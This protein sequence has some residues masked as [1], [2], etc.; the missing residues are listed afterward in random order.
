VTLDLAIR[1]GQVLTPDGLRPGT[2]AV[3]GGRIVAIL[4]PEAEPVARETV[5][6][7]GL[8]VLPGAIDIH[9]HIR[10]PAYPNRGSVESETGAAAKGGITTLF[11]M[12]ITDP[13]CNSPD[14]VA[15]RRDHF[16]TRALTDFAMFAAPGG[17]DREA[18]F[19]R[20]RDAG[21]IALKIFTTAAPPAATGS[22][23][24]SPG[25]TPTRR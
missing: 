7:G 5:E 24:A 17:T 3:A 14:R 16:A 23:R 4:P 15:L 25:P 2:V 18:A 8:H 1:G 12:P 9:C 13:C 22:S 10:S 11:E 6:A 19:E 20:L 21:V